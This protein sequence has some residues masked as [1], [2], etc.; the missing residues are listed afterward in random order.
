[1]KAGLMQSS[2]LC[3][4]NEVKTLFTAILIRHF[5]NLM[6]M[7]ESNNV[8]CGILFPTEFTKIYLKQGQ[9]PGQ[10]SVEYIREGMGEEVCHIR[11]NLPNWLHFPSGYELRL[12]QEKQRVKKS[13]MTLRTHRDYRHYKQRVTKACTRM[14]ITTELGVQKRPLQKHATQA[15]QHFSEGHAGLGDAVR[16]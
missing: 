8:L 3:Q 11:P 6:L 4:A 16:M 9:Q 15:L 7:T 10:G 1:M 5:Q 13:Q 14:G 2:V 12:M